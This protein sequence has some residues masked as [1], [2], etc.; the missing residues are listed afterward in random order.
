MRKGTGALEVQLE[1]CN[2]TVENMEVTKKDS[3]CSWGAIM[4]V[5]VQDV[6][7]CDIAD[8]QVI[9]NTDDAR[10]SQLHKESNATKLKLPERRIK[11]KKL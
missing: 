10:T 7:D 9:Q 1:T 4:D 2:D 6:D 11:S 5:H 8:S 3:V